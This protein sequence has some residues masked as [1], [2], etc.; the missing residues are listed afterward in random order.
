MKRILIIFKGLSSIKKCL[1]PKSEPLKNEYTFR[2]SNFLIIA[3]YNYSAY[4]LFDLSLLLTTLPDKF[5]IEKFI[6]QWSKSMLISVSI[7]FF[8]F[9]CCNIKC[10][11]TWY[12]IRSCYS[13][14]TLKICISHVFATLRFLL[15]VFFLHFKLK[16]N[17]V[18]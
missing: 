1:R 13:S 11:I 3:L 17:V 10:F 2:F 6:N 9:F 14:H 7:F 12:F 5:F 15:S 16:V 18:L 4:S 8:F